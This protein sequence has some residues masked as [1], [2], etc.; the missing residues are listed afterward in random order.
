M[1]NIDDV[2]HTNAAYNTSID[3]S[4]RFMSYRGISNAFVVSG[5]SIN[6][7]AAVI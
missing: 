6:M 4:A 1:A 3:S 2:E 5:K 7:N